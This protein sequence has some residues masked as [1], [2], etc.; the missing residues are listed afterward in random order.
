MSFSLH[1]NS[2]R[3]DQSKFQNAAF[4]LVDIQIWIYFDVLNWR[5]R[6]TF[7]FS[8]SRNSRGTP[9]FCYTY[10][11]MCRVSILLQNSATHTVVFLIGS[12]S[13][14]L[15]SVTKDLPQQPTLL[16]PIWLLRSANNWNEPSDAL[17]TLPIKCLFDTSFSLSWKKKSLIFSIW[18]DFESQ[19][20]VLF[21]WLALCLFT[22]KNHT[23]WVCWFFP[24]I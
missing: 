5:E 17:T 24:K 23:L 2:A 18:I 19:I 14:F 7:K 11:Q 16:V 4:L 13:F 6:E 21:N 1:V 15:L 3:K 12:G 9:V 8:R 10:F 20:L 22:K